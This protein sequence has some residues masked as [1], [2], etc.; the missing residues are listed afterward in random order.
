MTLLKAGAFKKP[1]DGFDLR[2]LCDTTLLPLCV[3]QNK[4]WQKLKTMVHF[5]PF[6]VS[7]KKR[8]PWVQLAGHAGTRW[9]ER[10]RRIS[11]LSSHRSHVF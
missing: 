7:F 10:F 11:M 8:Y 9:G 4:S 3:S 2:L 1:P 5:S 6:V